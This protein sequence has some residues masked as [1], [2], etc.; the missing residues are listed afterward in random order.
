M[1]HRKPSSLTLAFIARARAIHGDRY[2]YSKSQYRCSETKLTIICPVH[3]P[4]RQSPYNHTSPRLKCGCQLCAARRRADLEIAQAGKQFVQ[5]AR[6]RHGDL[7]DYSNVSY[8]GARSKVCIICPFHGSFWQQADSHLRQCGCLKCGIARRAR[9]KV[10]RASESFV[11][12]ARKIHGQKFDYSQV[13]YVAARDKVVMGCRKHGPFLQTPNHHLTGHGCPGC[14]RDRLRRLFAKPA[15]KFQRQARLIHGSRYLYA[16]DY[17]SGKVP[18][19]ITCPEHGTFRQL[20]SN[21]L[22][23]ARCPKCANLSQAQTRALTH[24]EF[25]AKAKIVHKGRGYVYTGRYRRALAKVSINCRRHGVF[26]QTPNNHLK[27]HGCP[28]CF[29]EATA[30]RLRSD[31]QSFLR[32]ARKVHG[33][34]Y[35]YPAPYQASEI[36]IQIVC[37]D[38]GIF[39]QRPNKHLQGQGCPICT[40][41]SGERFVALA[42]DRMGMHYQRQKTFPSCRDKRPLRFDFHIPKLKVLVEY[43]GQQHF[44]SV[45]HWGG[46]ES[47]RDGVR[48]DKI[49]GRWAKR[50]GY[51][52]VRIPFTTR[53]IP[54]AIE[55]EL[56]DLHQ[57]RLLKPDPAVK[58]LPQVVLKAA[59]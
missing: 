41:S 44:Q 28:K 3:G 17:V 8:K 5:R 21:H 51:R 20:P 49:K 26:R 37:P 58:D 54:A 34:R 24:N 55:L 23:G 10:Q 33:D 18:I 59:K 19:S 11:R 47:L 4:F 46:E 29:A 38:H 40:D 30:E 12:K 2:D 45:E 32:R 48:R 50:N 16:D 42:L 56:V 14:H 39:K 27:G 15:E 9:L 53:D 1:A 13:R 35:E 31:N 22:R 6:A 52:L 36:P 43:D 7:Y 57:R 25:V